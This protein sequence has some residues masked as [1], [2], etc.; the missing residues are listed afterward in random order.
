MTDIAWIELALTAA[1][2]QA[3]GALLRC[4]RDLDT[5]EDFNALIA[6]GRNLPDWLRAL[7]IQLQETIA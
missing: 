4:F 1:R 6:S 3:L 7:P 2:P 5:A